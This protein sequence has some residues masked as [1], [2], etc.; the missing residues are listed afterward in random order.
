MSVNNENI[1]QVTGHV[2]IA[3]DV[4]NVGPPS[5]VDNTCHSV[6]QQTAIFLRRIY[7]WI[8]ECLDRNTFRR[9]FVYRGDI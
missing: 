3:T 4:G 7:S 6:R 1:V 8:E 2:E 5:T 9:F